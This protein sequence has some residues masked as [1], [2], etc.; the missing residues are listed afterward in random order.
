MALLEHFCH[1]LSIHS[2]D[3]M[4][5][6]LE[7]YFKIFYKLDMK[8]GMIK[9]QVLRSTGNIETEECKRDKHD[10]MLHLPQYEFKVGSV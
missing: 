10:V 2:M 7:A 8:N 1:V 4:S 9:S 6:F 5:I 3:I